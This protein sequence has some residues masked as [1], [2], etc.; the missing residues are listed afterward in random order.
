M[1]YLDIMWKAIAGENRQYVPTI[2]S[3]LEDTVTASIAK[4]YGNYNAMIPK[5]IKEA[6]DICKSEE[7]G[8]GYGFMGSPKYFEA[9]EKIDNY[10]KNKITY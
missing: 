10:F 3:S 1:V 4:A 9:K 7:L 6:M 2:Y 8:G 5:N